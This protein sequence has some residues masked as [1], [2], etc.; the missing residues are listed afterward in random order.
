MLQLGG[1][2]LKGT[3]LK[4]LLMQSVGVGSLLFQ[5]VESR[6]LHDIME[7]TGGKRMYAQCG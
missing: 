1:I 6:K 5:E 4:G 7:Y 2:L 3:L